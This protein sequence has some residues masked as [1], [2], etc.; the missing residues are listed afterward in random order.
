M[1]KTGR[2][3]RSQIEADGAMTLSLEQVVIPEPG[4]DEL[5]VRVEAAPINP[6]DLGLLTGC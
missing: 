3:L 4:D 1:S 6:T 5:V 2:E